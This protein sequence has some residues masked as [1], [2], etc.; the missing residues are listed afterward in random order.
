MLS[1]LQAALRTGLLGRDDAEAR[2]AV[3]NGDGLAPDARIEIYR[4][5]VFQS[6]VGVLAAAYPTVANVLGEAAFRTVA[7]AFIKSRPPRQP[8]LSAYG[9]ELPEF[10]AALGATRHPYLPD[11]ARLEWARNECYFAA[12]AAP[13]DLGLLGAVPPERTPLL[14][15]SLHPAVRLLGSR[16]DL[17]AIWRE[18]LGGGGRA[19]DAGGEGD[20]YILISRTGLEVQMTE[21]SA[22][23]FTLALGLKLGLTLGRAAHAAT[24][25]EPAF[26]LEASLARLLSHST[27]TSFVLSDPAEEVRS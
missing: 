8:Q 26:A 22:G 12:D 21:L 19:Q 18:R 6:L 2:A 9:G 11:L 16:H 4:N 1:D 15:L 5:N 23:A 7:A 10:L 24:L 13:L 17:V 20:H 14:R 27:F 25:S 3:A